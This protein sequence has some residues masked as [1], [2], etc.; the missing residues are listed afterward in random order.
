MIR[1]II[2]TFIMLSL[3]VILYL[4]AKVLPRIGD[5]PENGPANR[6]RVMA[7]LEKAD[8]LLKNFLEKILRQSRVWILKLDYLIGL[9]LSRFKKDAPKE[10][11][12]PP[13][14]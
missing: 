2:Q 9:K 14:N 12:L 1:F 4:M 5:E 7:Y 8:E 10:T 3:A 6:S 11:K 13:E